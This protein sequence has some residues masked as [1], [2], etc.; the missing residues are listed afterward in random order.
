MFNKLFLLLFF[1]SAAA[2][3]Q[4]A[5]DNSH[6]SVGLSY[7]NGSEFSNTDYTYSNN[8]IQ[9]QAYYTINPGRKWEYQVA[10]QP[11]VNFARHRLKNLYFVT[12]DDPHYIE[13]REQYTKLKDIREYILNVAFFV[14]R[15]FGENFSIYA[16]GNVG[17]MITDTETERL[18]EGFAFCD[19]F[20][21]GIAY[22]IGDVILDVRPNVRHT[23]NAG[24]QQSNA[25]FNTRNIAFGIIVEL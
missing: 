8:Y 17:P 7:G 1:C 5:E 19:V 3:A 2:Y 23:S 9:G 18:T 22:K 15:N 14:R 20:A 10:L 12:P 11:E 4:Q 24:L 13:K 25:G 21:I 6:F 16:M